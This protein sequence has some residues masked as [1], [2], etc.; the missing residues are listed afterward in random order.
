[1][2]VLS[3]K[4]PHGD[5]IK[6][7]GIHFDC[8][9]VMSATVEDLAKTC[10]WKLKAILRTS[11]FK[12]GAAWANLYKSQIHSF[13]EYRTTARYHA[14]DSALALLDTVQEKVLKKW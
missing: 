8:K 3:R 11:R 9:L 12:I 10:R 7:L 14:C 4:R 13:I 5:D 6:L 2:Y 1:M